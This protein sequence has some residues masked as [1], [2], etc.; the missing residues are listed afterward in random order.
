M[1]QNCMQYVKTNFVR[2]LISL[3][4][5]SQDITRERFVYVPLVNMEELW[6]DKKL[7]KR[8]GLT[9]DEIIFIE[10]MIRPMERNND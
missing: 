7:Y 6:T 8:Y 3:L 5:F 9:K 1:A 2:F 10:S 4:S